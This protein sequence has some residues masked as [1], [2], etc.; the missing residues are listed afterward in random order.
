MFEAE[1]VSVWGTYYT[2]PSRGLP[3]RRDDETSLGGA[4]GCLEVSLTRSGLVHTQICVLHNYT[5]QAF[6]M[7][8][9]C[10][11]RDADV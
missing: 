1:W 7:T 5:F 8:F 6:C 11:A 9:P 10:E 2:T 4:F 3:D